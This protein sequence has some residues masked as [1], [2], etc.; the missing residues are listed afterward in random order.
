VVN[1]DVDIESAE[2][3]MW[4]MSNRILATNKV[5]SES[6]VDEWWNHLKLGI[7]TTVDVN[8]IRHKRPTLLPF[9]GRKV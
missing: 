7:D 2:D 1:D 9:Q 8:D 6:C 3:V 4:A 5:I